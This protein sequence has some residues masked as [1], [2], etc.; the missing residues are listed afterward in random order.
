MHINQAILLAHYWNCYVLLILDNFGLRAELL[1]DWKRKVA[2]LNVINSICNIQFI[3]C[4]TTMVFNYV[5]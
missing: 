3:E 1:D 5:L 4:F 2:A